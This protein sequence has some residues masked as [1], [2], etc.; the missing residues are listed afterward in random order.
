MNARLDADPANSSQTRRALPR[1][2]TV[3]E[4][5]AKSPVWRD[6]SCRDHSHRTGRD[7]SESR[8]RP[9]EAEALQPVRPPHPTMQHTNGGRTGCSEGTAGCQASGVLTTVTVDTP[10]PAGSSWSV[11]YKLPA[12]AK[13]GPWFVTGL[14]LSQDELDGNVLQATFNV[15][16]PPPTSA[17]KAVAWAQSHLGQAYDNGLCLTFVFDAWTA[18][19]VNLRPKVTVTIGN[20]TY[21]V[22]IWNH[23]NSGTTGT[24]KTPPVGALVFWSS[25]LGRTNSH[26]ALEHG[27]RQ[28]DLDFRRRERVGGSRRNDRT[29]HFCDI[30]LSGLVDACLDRVLWACLR[31]RT[32][33]RTRGRP[34]RGRGQWRIK[35]KR[36]SRAFALLAH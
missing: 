33:L 20:D 16:A 34:R 1:P 31:V 22:D 9:I 8:E 4:V 30:G 26:V 11:N 21:P 24:N 23:F 2:E 19:G 25:T 7:R 32:Q 28:P 36:A 12:S 35:G 13:L 27:Q 3:L 5:L 29:A 10:L 18:G 17:Q 15:A 14:C 6:G